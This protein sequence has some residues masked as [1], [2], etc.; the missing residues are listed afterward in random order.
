MMQGLLAFGSLHVFDFLVSHDQL[1]TA[2]AKYC[3]MS[4]I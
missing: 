2:L 4:Q 1:R 3:V